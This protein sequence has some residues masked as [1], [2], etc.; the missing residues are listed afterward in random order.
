MLSP[1]GESV[2]S[3]GPDGLIYLYPVNG[4][5]PVAVKGT[6]PGEMP[7]GW[8]KDGKSIFVYRFGEIPAQV[9]EVDLSTGQRKLWK[10]L[11]PSDSAGIDTIRGLDLSMDSKSYVYGY[12]R[13]LSD[14]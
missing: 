12:I 10:Q 14:L 1:N 7:T 3:T 11:V 6:E 13:T 9:F 5:D 2:A 4:G 8:S